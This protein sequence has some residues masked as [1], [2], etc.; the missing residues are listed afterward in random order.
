MSAF[1]KS[2]TPI[3]SRRR[4][5]F[6]FLSSA[7]LV[8]AFLFGGRSAIAQETCSDLTALRLPDVRIV[9]A[10]VIE[11]GE[12]GNEVGEA[13]HCRVEGVIGRE[14]RFELLLPETWNGRFAMGGGGGFVGSIQNAAR[15]SVHSGYA[16]VGTDTGHEGGGTDASWALHHP[17][18]Q[19]NF[20]HLAVH[21]TAE[22][23]ESDHPRSLR[24][25]HRLFV[26]PRVFAGRRT[27]SHGSTAVSGRFRRDIV[28]RPGLRLDRHYGGR[29]AEY[30]ETLSRS[31][32]NRYAAPVAGPPLLSGKGR[33]GRMRCARRRA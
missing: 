9:E 22:T 27:G 10:A 14:I 16:T 21:R 20:G 29:V 1:Q 28:R 32:P 31:F 3:R 13:P 17:E 5:C 26:L 19:I 2:V 8:A 24:V 25:G 4:D 12:Q 30:A 15:W 11:P 18:R 33:A 7:L 23:A 6:R